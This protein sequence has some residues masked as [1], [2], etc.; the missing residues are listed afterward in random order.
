MASFPGVDI[1]YTSSSTV[2]TIVKAVLPVVGLATAG[3][4]VGYCR[5][6][7]ALTAAGVGVLMPCGLVFGA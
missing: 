4:A 7:K 6:L 5:L 3:V 1:A 2:L